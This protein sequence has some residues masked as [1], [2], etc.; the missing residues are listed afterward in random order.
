VVS[1][2]P[3][4]FDLKDESDQKQ[5]QIVKIFENEAARAKAK[6]KTATKKILG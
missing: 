2:G 1:S 6:M 4:E 5:Q 3:I